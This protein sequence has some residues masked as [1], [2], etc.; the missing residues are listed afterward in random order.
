[1]IIKTDKAIEIA[2]EALWLDWQSCGSPWG[3][4]VLQDNPEANKEAVWGNAYNKGDYPG[5]R[6]GLREESKVDADYVFG[7]M[8]K[9]CFKVTEDSI[10][11]PEDE[12][13]ID[14]QSWCKDYKT[15]KALF[16]AASR[17]IGEELP[18]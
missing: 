17:N 2:K 11:I 8:M 15:Y 9:L 14:Y 4:G 1:M 13:Q 7:R 18:V 16:T 5:G 10:N 3:M 12:C 6:L